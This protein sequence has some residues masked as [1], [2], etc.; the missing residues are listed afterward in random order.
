MI[1][2]ICEKKADW[3]WRYSIIGP[4]WLITPL[5]LLQ[6]FPVQ[7][8]LVFSEV[9][10][11]PL[12]NYYSITPFCRQCLQCYYWHPMT[13]GP[14]LITVTHYQAPIALHLRLVVD[15]S[16][17]IVDLPV[18]PLLIWLLFIDMTCPLLLTYD[19]LMWN[20]YWYCWLDDTLV[21][22]EGREDHGNIDV[23]IPAMC[24]VEDVIITG[25]QWWTVE[26]VIDPC[27]VKKDTHCWLPD[28]GVLEGPVQYGIG[29]IKM[30]CWLKANPPTT[31]I[32]CALKDL[33]HSDYCWKRNSAQ[34]LL[35]NAITGPVLTPVMILMTSVLLVDQM[36]I[37]YE[38]VPDP[39]M[40]LLTQ[41]ESLK[42]RYSWLSID[43]PDHVIE[44][45]NG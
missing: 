8:L 19:Q 5:L 9:L 15:T 45:I 12:Y 29:I 16:L 40:T 28:G 41:W 33:T 2:I 10:T 30:T 1:P 39:A 35:E 42:W 13:G 38:K 31:I 3:L 34:Y 21:L 25:R 4:E 17:L 27:S 32:D 6:L 22:I 7:L 20:C 36:I 14:V 44:E 11:G 23:T 37:V 43:Q 26:A 24:G 18:F